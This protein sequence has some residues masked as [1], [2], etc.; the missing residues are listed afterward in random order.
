MCGGSRS[1]IMWL[2]IVWDGVLGVIS[3]AES[4]LHKCLASVYLAMGLFQTVIF[5]GEFWPLL[6]S[7]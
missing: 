6:W 2:G 7:L 5:L 4:R 1:V 3:I